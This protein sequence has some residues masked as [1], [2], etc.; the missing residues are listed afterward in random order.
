MIIEKC[1]K[2][3]DWVTSF[4]LNVVWLNRVFLLL[5]V[6][7]I[8]GGLTNSIIGPFDGLD[9]ASALT[10]SFISLIAGHLVSGIVANDSRTSIPLFLVTLIFYGL[11]IL[12]T[13]RGIELHI[14]PEVYRQLLGH[15]SI[16]LLAFWC[17]II[18]GNMKSPPWMGNL[19]FKQHI[20]PVLKSRGIKFM[21]WNSDGVLS[22]VEI[23]DFH[24]IWFED[25]DMVKV[26]GSQL[27]EYSPVQIDEKNG[28]LINP[29]I[30]QV[31]QIMSTFPP[32][33]TTSMKRHFEL[34][35]AGSERFSWLNLLQLLIPY[36]PSSLAQDRYSIATNAIGIDIEGLRYRFSWPLPDGLNLSDTN[37]HS[38]PILHYFLET[39]SNLSIIGRDNKTQ[40]I[41][42]IEKDITNSLFP[43]LSSKQ[44]STTFLLRS[45][46]HLLLVLRQEM[47]ISKGSRKEQCRRSIIDVSQYFQSF[48]FMGDLPGDNQQAFFVSMEKWIMWVEQ[49]L[50]QPATVFLRLHDILS[51]E[52]NSG[53]FDEN[54]SIKQILA[55]LLMNCTNLVIENAAFRPKDRIENDIIANF[56]TEV[57]N[58]RTVSMLSGIWRM[59]LMASLIR[60]PE[61]VVI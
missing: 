34:L 36:K 35:E 46:T 4:D 52:I 1:K 6:T 60:N 25:E 42:D 10:F 16:C 3:S 8:L 23:E 9:V 2:F 29:G 51:E 37:H 5:L 28:L 56:S 17:G 18:S 58:K 27:D 19:L 47:D 40:D 55:G 43:R 12:L 59:L 39:N 48:D 22:I 61:E 53:H 26:N 33:W 49:S 7:Y 21:H 31:L 13:V 30:K 50:S 32:L 11:F 38:K 20:L 57:G 24:P 45:F 15:L 44:K 14:W 54:T 41:I